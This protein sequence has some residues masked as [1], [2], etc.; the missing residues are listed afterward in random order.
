MAV[1]LFLKDRK[2]KFEER[3]VGYDDDALHELAERHKSRSIPTVII[4]DEVVIG[5][6]P[7][8]LDHLLEQ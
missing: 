1:K 7:E 2:A 5:F 6:D 4:G 8:R 3:C